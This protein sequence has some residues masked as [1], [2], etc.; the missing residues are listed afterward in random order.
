ML[1]AA[2]GT[3]VTERRATTRFVRYWTSLQRAGAVPSLESLDPRWMPF[4]WEDCFLATMDDGGAIGFRHTGANLRAADAAT[5]PSEFL[6][7]IFIAA[8]HALDAAEPA[9]GSGEHPLPEGGRILYRFAAMRFVEGRGR[10]DVLL[11]AVT[12]RRDAA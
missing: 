10:P 9:E 7:L 1:D 4:S 6:R 11:V 8:R 5:G 3:D 2:F 12:Q